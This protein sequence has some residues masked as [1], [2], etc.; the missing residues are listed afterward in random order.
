MTTDFA[1]DTTTSFSRTA[2]VEYIDLNQSL[3]HQDFYVW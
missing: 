2:P 3:V 1:V